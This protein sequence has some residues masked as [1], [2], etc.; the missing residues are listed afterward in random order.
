MLGKEHSGRSISTWKDPKQ[1]FDWF[2]EPQEQHCG[3]ADAED[4][5]MG[6]KER[7]NQRKVT[8]NLAET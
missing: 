5:A 7:G 4:S 6:K 1:L 3:W 2:S 8:A